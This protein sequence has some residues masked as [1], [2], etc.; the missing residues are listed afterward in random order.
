MF[1][2][3]GVLLLA[4]RGAVRN[5]RTVRQVHYVVVGSRGVVVCVPGRGTSYLTPRSDRYIWNRLC[6][7]APASVCGPPRSGTYP[8]PCSVARYNEMHLCALG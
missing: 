7:V 4:H 6:L 8:T 1:E 5:F 2:G 3:A